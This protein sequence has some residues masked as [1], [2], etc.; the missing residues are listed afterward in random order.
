MSKL[1]NF[2]KNGL[3]KLLDKAMV[4]IFREKMAPDLKHS[5]MVFCILWLSF[6]LYNIF[7]NLTDSLTYGIFTA[8]VIFVFVEVFDSKFT[9]GFSKK[10][11]FFDMIGLFVGIISIL[12]FI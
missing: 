5:V 8:I 12:L 2:I 11:I 10:D 9:T 4:F 3:A 6:L 7:F 1:Y